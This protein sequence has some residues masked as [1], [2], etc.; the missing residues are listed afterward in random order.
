[1]PALASFVLPGGSPGAA[2]ALA[3]Q[4]M[5][6]L[7]IAALAVLLFDPWAVLQP[8]FWLSFAAVALLISSEPAGAAGLVQPQRR[9]PRATARHP[10]SPTSA[11]AARSARGGACATW[12]GGW[13]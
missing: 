13:R 4:G 7:A 12:P 2:Q 11:G 1:L 9:W 8:G 3:G 5:R 6:V 10:A